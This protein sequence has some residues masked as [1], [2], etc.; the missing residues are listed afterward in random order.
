MSGVAEGS[1]DL[2]THLV[3]VLS[4]HWE[5]MGLPDGAQALSLA[6]EDP[7]DLVV[8]EVTM[9]GMDGLAL[10]GALRAN[11]ATAMVPVMLIASRPGEEAA[12]EASRMRDS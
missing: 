11:P 9:R 6:K 7:P 12:G 4:R 8:A 3:Q 5:V 10:L 1:A 2:R